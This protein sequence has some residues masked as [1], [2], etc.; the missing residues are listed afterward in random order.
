MEGVCCRG[1]SQAAVA[2][3]AKPSDASG[4]GLD[5]I[6]TVVSMSNRHKTRSKPGQQQ[7]RAQLA[8]RIIA[9]S[10]FSSSPPP[11]PRPRPRRPPLPALAP[12]PRARPLSH[13]RTRLIRCRPPS[14]PRRRRLC[15]RRSAA[16]RAVATALARA[17]AGL[18]PRCSRFLSY[19]L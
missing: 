5:W 15:S 7:R 11:R 3:R 14:C 13:P 2:A 19:A 17:R 10:P 1:G 18:C 8:R 16:L 4:R 6:G 12:K 9:T